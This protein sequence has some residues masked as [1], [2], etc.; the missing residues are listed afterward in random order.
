M[1]TKG[2]RTQV[3]AG[4]LA[5]VGLLLV[6]TLATAGDLEPNEPPAPT[7]KTLDEI[8]DAAASVSEREGYMKTVDI[9]PNSSYTFFTVPAGKQFVLLKLFVEQPMFLTSSGGLY[10][11]WYTLPNTPLP[12]CIDFPDRCV[13]INGGEMVE[14]SNPDLVYAG[15]AT[16]L[17]YFYDVE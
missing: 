16:V 10:I 6:W 4:L 15:K 14:V 13:V 12:S 3:L 5:L 8:Y 7:M 11:D 9:D 2:K 17:G 1:E